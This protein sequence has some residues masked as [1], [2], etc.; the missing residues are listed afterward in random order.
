MNLSC[1]SYNL[2][3]Y[4]WH[5]PALRQ[6]SDPVARL[7]AILLV[8]CC[9][10]LV[11]LHQ[12]KGFQWSVD[13]IFLQIVIMVLMNYFN[14]GDQANNFK[15]AVRWVVLLQ[16]IPRCIRF[17]PLLAGQSQSGFVFETAW[18]NFIVN[19]FIYLLASHVVGCSWY[20]FGLQVRCNPSLDLCLLSPGCTS[21]A[22]WTW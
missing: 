10:S 22:P 20:L 2:P 3:C 21:C 17:F 4:R 14:P 18:A 11:S 7:Y 5:C 16:M 15:N 8:V 9:G 13:W 1:L 19:I 6:L 12:L